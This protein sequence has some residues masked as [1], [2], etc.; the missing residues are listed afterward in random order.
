MPI[1]SIRYEIVDCTAV[2]SV[3]VSADTMRRLSRMD[4]D[5]SIRNPNVRVA[6]VAAAPVI[7]GFARIYEF[8]GGD[9]PWM[10][11]VFETEEEARAWL[12]G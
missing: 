9:Q 5:Q 3:S 11:K 1:T 4:R 2:V 6:V 8:T 7:R 12:A 10:T